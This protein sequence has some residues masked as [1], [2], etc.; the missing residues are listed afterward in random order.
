M[1]LLLYGSKGWIGK[2]FVEY[3]N[4]NKIMF[5]E[6]N[7]RVENFNVLQNEINYIKPTHIISFIGRTNGYVGDKYYPTIDYLEQNKLHENIRDNLLCPLH[8]AI[9]CKNNDIHF[10]YI[11]TG[12]IF[13]YDSEHDTENGMTEESEPNFFGSSYSIVKGIT[14]K[15]MHLYPVLNLRIRMPVINRRDP[16]NFIT[17]LLSYKKICSQ[18]NSISVL[19]SL[20]PII[21]TMIINKEIGTFNMVNP[22]II[23]HNE[24]LELYKEI[25]DTNFYWDNMTEEEQNKVLLCKR[26]NTYLDTSKLQ[27]LFPNVKNVKDAIKECLIKYNGE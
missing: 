26:S 25:I 8:L 3:F 24:I 4:E 14:D 27:K 18:P 7:S 11:G 21:N 1:R 22:G 6:G 16:R 9:I 5:I 10:T 19:P 15:I 20:F 23:T 2:Q 13:E 17:K 12:C